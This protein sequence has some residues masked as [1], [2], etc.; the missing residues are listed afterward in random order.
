MSQTNQ[1]RKGCAYQNERL[2]IFKLK[3]KVAC[4]DC[5]SV[6]SIAE[7]EI[8]KKDYQRLNHFACCARKSVSNMEW[9]V[10]VACVRR[11]MSIDV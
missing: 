9:C 4:G 1:R 8:T 2:L 6:R 7:V 11:L 10:C 5:H 3:T